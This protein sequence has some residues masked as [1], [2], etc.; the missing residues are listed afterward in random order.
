ME[1]V[2]VTNSN[3]Q[4]AL[5][6][7]VRAPETPT[8]IAPPLDTVFELPGGF[9]NYTGEV[10]R[11]VE[12]R[13]LTGKDEEALAK[14]SS[15]AKLLNTALLRGIVR[16]GSEKPDESLVNSLYSG[17]RDYIL[18]R[19]YTTTFG[20]DLETTRYCTACNTNV[21][22]KFDLLEKVVVKKI[23]LE[24]ALFTVET[25]RGT[26]VVSL[27]TGYAQTA[28]LAD[29]S[30][31]LAELKTVLLENTVKKIGEQDLIL[32]KHGAV[33]RLTIRDRRAIDKELAERQFGPQL[34]DIKVEC[35]NCGTDME[36]PLSTAGL[37]QF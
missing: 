16:V 33:L 37:F 32:D 1:E 10:L 11:E 27:P 13:E 3:I 17:D 18:M 25:S 22:L 26:A 4:A 14:A 15:L 29:Q 9:V 35:P 2:Q 5:A 31:T 23:G 30:R 36:V 19:I 7:P 12:V 8:V 24:D 34:Q 28:M 20:S 6:E 21:D